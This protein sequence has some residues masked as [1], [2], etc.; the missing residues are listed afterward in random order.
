MEKMEKPL[1]DRE[2]SAADPYENFGKR[3][4]VS[5]ELLGKGQL[6][7]SDRLRARGVPVSKTAL[8]KLESG[9]RAVKL[10][11]AV[12]LCDILGLDLNLRDLNAEL[13]E[14]SSLIEAAELRVSEAEESVR[15]AQNELRRA[16]ARR[17]ARALLRDAAKTPSSTFYWEGSSGELLRD[18][19]ASDQGAAK[20]ALRA[21]GVPEEQ[22]KSRAGGRVQKRTHFYAEV[23]LG[24][25]L[26]NLECEGD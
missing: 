14:L 26:P 25:W 23:R 1:S 17:A 18:A 6:W 12:A 5:R 8:S 19:F 15:A 4:R 22:L 21:I 10:A 2:L 9:E 24:D 16:E 13:D 20:V 3:V 7:L 11:E